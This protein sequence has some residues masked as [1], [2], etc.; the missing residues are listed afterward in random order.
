MDDDERADKIVSFLTQICSEFGI[1]DPLYYIESFTSVE[2]Y[3][4]DEFVRKVFLVEGMEPE[5]SMQL[6]RQVKRKF[7]ERFGSYI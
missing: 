7:I 2:Y 3:N 1:C 6:L 5:L 4:V